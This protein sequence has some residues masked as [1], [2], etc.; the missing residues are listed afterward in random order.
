MKNDSIAL[1]LLGFAEAMG[2]FANICPPPGEIRAAVRQSDPNLREDLNTAC[3][4]STA[5]AM[6][7]HTLTATWLPWRTMSTKSVRESQG[8]RN[9]R[10]GSI[11]TWF[12]IPVSSMPSQCQAGMSSLAGGYYG[13]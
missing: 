1:A 4:H 5:T 3:L 6:L 8:M 12:P 11:F 10:S 9:A 13:K 2:A 7:N